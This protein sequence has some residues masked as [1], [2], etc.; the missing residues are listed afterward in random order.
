ME[1]P[2]GHLENTDDSASCRKCGTRFDGDASLTRT[3]DTAADGIARGT[4]FAGR[5][6]IIEELGASGMGRVYRAFDRKI[7]ED[8]ALKL[9]PPSPQC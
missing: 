4:L 9:L 6:E 8:I 5:Y 3:L 7:G 1:C 2:K